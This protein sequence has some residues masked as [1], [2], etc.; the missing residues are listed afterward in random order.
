M[1]AI[2]KTRHHE[3]SG[4]EFR[5]VEVLNNRIFCLD[6]N[7]VKTD[8]GA[9]EI[10]IVPDASMGKWILFSFTEYGDSHFRNSHIKRIAKRAATTWNQ[11]VSACEKAIHTYISI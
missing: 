5:I 2:I 6:I 10:E 1:R 3:Y 9:S 4:Q 7:G 11:K 8:F